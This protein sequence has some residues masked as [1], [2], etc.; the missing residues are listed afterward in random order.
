MKN[1]KGYITKSESYISHTHH[2]IM[3]RDAVTDEILKTATTLESILFYA[4][5]HYIQLPLRSLDGTFLQ[6]MDGR[7][8]YRG[9]SL[10]GVGG[11]F[12]YGD[13]TLLTDV[14]LCKEC[15]SLAFASEIDEAGRMGYMCSRCGHHEM[16]M[17][18][19]ELIGALD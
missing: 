4:H 11:V 12:E 10:T 17:P 16:E 13:G 14:E 19:H 6:D 7:F 18:L 9:E 1:R 15:G 2:E 5:E 8:V 3:L